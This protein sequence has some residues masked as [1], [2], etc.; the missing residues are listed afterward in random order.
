MIPFTTE[1]VIAAFQSAPNIN[2]ALKNLLKKETKPGDPAGRFLKEL[3]ERTGRPNVVAL[4]SFVNANRPAGDGLLIGIGRYA[5]SEIVSPLL[6]GVITTYAD[7][8]NSLYDGVGADGDKSAGDSIAVKNPKRFAE[9]V[10]EVNKSI[11]QGLR[12]EQ[13]SSATRAGSSY[14]K[15]VLLASVFDPPVLR[16]IFSQTGIVQNGVAP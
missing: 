1:E 9:I 2:A 14:M 4:T 8:F 3:K 15:N 10:Q 13:L 12:S 5:F 6:D 7:E 11:D 16:Y